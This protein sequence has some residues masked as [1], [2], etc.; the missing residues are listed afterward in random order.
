[1][2]TILQKKLIQ[3]WEDSKNQAL[4]YS[5]IILKGLQ[6]FLML[7]KLCNIWNMES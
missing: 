1:M 7:F 5:K 6:Y 2:T 3:V 4:L